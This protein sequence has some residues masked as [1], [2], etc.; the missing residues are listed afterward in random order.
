MSR[1]VICSLYVRSIHLHCTLR[2]G[3]RRHSRER[4]VLS[5][6]YLWL[7]FLVALSSTPVRAHDIYRHL[8]DGNGASCCSDK[9]CMPAPFRVCRRWRSDVCSGPLDRR[10]EQQNTIPDADR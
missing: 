9:D 3:P 10:P 2:G 6:S 5:K 4:P 8:V 1:V 7:F